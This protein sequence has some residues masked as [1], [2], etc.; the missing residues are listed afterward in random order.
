MG[1]RSAAPRPAP[2][3]SGGRRLVFALLCTLGCG[4]C[5]PL[6][7]QSEPS[8]W[9]EQIALL[10]RALRERPDDAELLVRRGS[11]WFRAGDNRQALRDFDR[12]IAL[13][14]RLEPYLWQRGISLYYAER[15]KDCRRQFEDHRLVNPNDVENAVW[16]FLCVA[17]AADV[18][19]AR[20]EML[21][22]G[23]D[24]RTPMRQIDALFRGVGDAADVLEALQGRG[25]DAR[26]Y[27]LLY[28][29]LWHEAHGRMGRADE[30]IAQ[31]AGIGFPHYMGD[32]ARLH[33]RLIG[34][35]APAP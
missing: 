17:R 12:A 30:L 5:S 6:W 11:A 23:P 34:R 28:L 2:S 32:V 21:P 1:D 16:H 25:P 4:F 24:S 3:L 35:E 10:D 14:Q 19:T 26:F 31:A 15:W 20:A 9:R 8:T 22:V 7:A 33:R 29:G 18:Q 13:D 27:A